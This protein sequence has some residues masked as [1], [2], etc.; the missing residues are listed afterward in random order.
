MEGEWTDAVL[1]GDAGTQ[2]SVEPEL[3]H[4]VTRQTIWNRKKDVQDIRPGD[5]SSFDCADSENR[6]PHGSRPFHN[7][8]GIIPSFHHS[9][10]EAVNG[11]QSLGIV[12]VG[13]FFGNDR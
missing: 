6:R 9:I 2:R 10:P 7:L 12:P 1:T 4:D 11:E 3:R 13:S 8:T 5:V